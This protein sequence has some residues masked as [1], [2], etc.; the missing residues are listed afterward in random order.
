MKSRCLDCILL[1]FY[2]IKVFK[3]YLDACDQ[4]R[5]IE[6]ITPVE[7]QEIIKKFALAVRKKKW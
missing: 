1:V 6:D 4:K 2:D 3:E 5:E 7:L